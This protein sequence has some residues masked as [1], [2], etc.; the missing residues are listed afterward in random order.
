MS[1][2][3]KGFIWGAACAAYQCEGAWDADG[4]G[5]SI[6]D[7]FAH[8]TGRG[9]VRNDENGDVACDVYH[10]Y[11]S[12]IALM[13]ELGYRV[14]RFSVNWPRVLPAGTG[15]VNEA[16]LAFYDR[17]VDALLAAGIEP[18]VT[19][20][21]WELPSALER[22]GGWLS[23]ATVDAFEQYAELMARRFGD[24]VKRYM[25]VNEPQCAVGL[26]YGNGMHAPGKQL[27]EEDLIRCMHHFALAH[28]AAQRAIKRVSPQALVG[29]APC[30]R[31]CYPLV[32]TE[33]G[34]EAAYNASFDLSGKLGPWTFTFNIFLDSVILRRYDESATPEM[35][36][37]AAGLPGSEWALMERPDF[38]GVNVYHGQAVD[39]NGEPAGRYPGFPQTA[40]KW[41]VAPEV[42]RYGMINLHKRYGLPLCITENGQACNDRIFLDGK[43]HDPDRIDYMHRYLLE[44]KKSID[45]GTP[46]FGYLHWSFL[47]NFEWADGFDE[48]FG[49]VFV[50]YRDQRRIPKDSA[51]WYRDVIRKNGENL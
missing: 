25:T 18:W 27:P 15:A 24:R 36:A 31:L 23:R 26:G 9:H 44:L 7:D 19:L 48:R 11:E 50:D 41:P 42:M 3:P 2:F 39:E 32:D 8:E 40:V 6:W 14:Y 28:S 37:F 33:K 20:Y 5:P 34:R 46:V 47:D 10:R 13:R 38:I 16:G 17:L 29:A 21:H 12:D 1:A 51:L 43:V 4:K 49:L 30:G 35:R 22:A 45:E